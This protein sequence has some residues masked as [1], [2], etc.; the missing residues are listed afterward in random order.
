ML[1]EDL[2]TVKIYYGYYYKQRFSE[3]VFYPTAWLLPIPPY[4]Q[5][6][7]YN[8]YKDRISEESYIELFVKNTKAF[9]LLFIIQKKP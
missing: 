5:G 7:S 3:S 2:I 9:A 6:Y 4:N 8:S 1:G